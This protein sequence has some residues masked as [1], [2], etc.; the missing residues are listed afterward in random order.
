MQSTQHQTTKTPL[1]QTKTRIKLYPMGR[2]GIREKGMNLLRDFCSR[3]NTTTKT[4]TPTIATKQST[5]F[6]PNAEDT[7]EEA[8]SENGAGQGGF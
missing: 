2:S 1:T 4:P 3:I 7:I 8:D 5:L 6:T